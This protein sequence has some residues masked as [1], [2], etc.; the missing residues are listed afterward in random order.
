[1]ESMTPEFQLDLVAARLEGLEESIIYRLLDRAQFACNPA[2]YRSGT[3]GFPEWPDASLFDIRLHLH[4]SMDSR[5]GRYLVPEERP[6][7]GLLP[8][9]ERTP[10]KAS[11]PFPLS[12]FGCIN[13][14]ARILADYLA[15]L[16]SLCREGDDGHYGSSVEMDIHCLQTSARR[17]HFGAL[18]VA[19]S[20]YRGA[21]DA[22]ADMIRAGDREGIMAALTRP[23]VEE[24]ILLR[25]REKLDWIQKGVNTVVRRLVDP[26]LIMEYYRATII[27]LTKEGEVA[28]LMERPL[29]VGN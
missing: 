19:E 20:K 3:S 8:G 27:P 11:S 26:D 16:E 15:L 18:Y 10:P 17:V 13:Q 1:M 2:A 29:G 9:P 5:F 21:P 24:R 28:Y 14:N 25:V 12:D 7:S 22:Y 6:F 23:E 4:E